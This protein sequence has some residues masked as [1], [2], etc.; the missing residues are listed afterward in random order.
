MSKPRCQVPSRAPKHFQPPR[1]HPMNRQDNS[2]PHK[3]GGREGASMGLGFPGKRVGPAAL[4]ASGS[5]SSSNAPPRLPIRSS[6]FVTHKGA[7]ALAA[8]AGTSLARDKQ[9]RAPLQVRLGGSSLRVYLFGN[10][11]IICQHAG[12]IAG[13]K[14]AKVLQESRRLVLC[15][16]KQE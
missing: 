13:C 12:I 11:L 10:K 4:P 8:G 1:P 5:S 3:P 9:P 2:E 7:S 16:L 14:S 15:L 6:T